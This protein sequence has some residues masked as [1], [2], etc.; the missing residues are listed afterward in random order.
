MCI[1][2]DEMKLVGISRCVTLMAGVCSKQ[3][4][5]RTDG[6]NTSCQ[7][8]N[9]R[10]GGTLRDVKEEPEANK[11]KKNKNPPQARLISG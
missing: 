11:V 10:L 2:N 8:I 3:P 5:N 6:L 4:S 7:R 9:T 1:C